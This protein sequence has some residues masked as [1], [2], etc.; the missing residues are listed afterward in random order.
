MS[1]GEGVARYPKPVGT[2]RREQR[3]D[4][5]SVREADVRRSGHTPVDVQVQLY[6]RFDGRIRLASHPA[7][8]SSTG[9][10]VLSAWSFALPYVYPTIFQRTEG[11]QPASLSAGYG[12]LPQ[13]C[14]SYVCCR[15]LDRCMTGH[16]RLGYCSLGSTGL[17]S[18]VASRVRNPHVRYFELVIRSYLLGNH[19]IAPHAVV[20]TELEMKVVGNI[21]CR[22]SVHHAVSSA[23]NVALSC[24][25][26]GPEG[27]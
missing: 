26:I 27:L 25:L 24:P 7:S 21:I 16:C 10:P 22:P 13:T 6:G 17:A 9:L 12:D 2:R 5:E 19:C 15:I 14:L 1:C 11:L 3:R 8:Q 4:G 23:T 20:A 18:L